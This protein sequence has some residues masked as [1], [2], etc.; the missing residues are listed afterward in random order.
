M[1]QVRPAHPGDMHALTRLYSAAFPDENLVPLVHELAD[2]AEVRSLIVEDAGT[3][4][5]HI[6]FSP[7]L[8]ER[9]PAR[10][11]LLGPLAIAPD[12][13]RKGLGTKLVREGL[14]LET[15]SRTTIALVLGDP[16]YYG[17]FGFTRE[18]AI[19]APYTLPDDWGPAWQSLTLGP[20]HPAGRLVVPDP[21]RDPM[22]WQP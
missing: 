22:L 14:R 17:R 5:G 20:T 9:D 10:A 16:A 18:T 6:A 21:W 7:C 8:I 15:G 13:Q 1:T 11:A 2:T 19:S 3:I 12:H 4:A